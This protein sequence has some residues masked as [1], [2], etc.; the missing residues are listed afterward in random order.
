MCV[1]VGGFLDIL[2]YFKRMPE[3]D[4]LLP[5]TFVNSFRWVS[6]GIQGQMG[7]RTWAVQLVGNSGSLWRGLTPT[8]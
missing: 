3:A 5:S 2:I 7:D 4:K 6:G 8:P 1:C